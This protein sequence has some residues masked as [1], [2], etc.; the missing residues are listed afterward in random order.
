MK[1][2][3]ILLLEPEPLIANDMRE[4]IL[5]LERD[6]VV[7]LAA[8]IEA[9]QAVA[10]RIGRIDLLIVSNC[11]GAFLGIPAYD[12]LAE[13]ADSIL[14]IGD[15]PDGPAA[16]ERAS[17]HLARAPFTSASLR[18]DLREITVAGAPLFPRRSPVLP[19]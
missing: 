18:E 11:S 14:V 9:A 7:E 3:H 16:R 6:A 17:V 1:S 12:G 19:R 13:T 4:E 8:S 15:A 10:A 5:A 2:S